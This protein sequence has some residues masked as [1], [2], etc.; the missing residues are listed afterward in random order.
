[1]ESSQG[2]RTE[3]E[4]LGGITFKEVHTQGTAKGLILHY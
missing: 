4:A 3:I 1:M 2:L